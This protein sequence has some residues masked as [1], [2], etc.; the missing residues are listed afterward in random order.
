M[1]DPNRPETYPRRVL[2]AVTGLSP[3]V[4]TETLYALAVQRRPPFIPTEVV[5]VTTRTGAEH[6]WLMLLSE[7]Q[8]WFH[9]FCQDYG[10]TGIAFAENSIR[11]L[12]D[13]QGN[14][15]DD[16][17]T[18]EDNECAADYLAD[19]VRELTQDPS[20]A[21]HVSIAGGRKTMGYYLGYALSLYGRLQDRL[22]HVLIS[23]PFES[24]PQFFYPTCA[25]RIIYALD[26]QQTPLDSSQAKVMLAEIPFVS[27][28]H[29][30]PEALL[31]GKARFSEAGGCGCQKALGTSESGSRSQ[32]LQ[33][34]RCRPDHSFVPG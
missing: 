22:S 8:G 26:K 4:V 13:S 20:C 33:D 15:A 1:Y 23:P 16:I 10:L 12:P 30:L 6:A 29:G 7:D 24:H 5:L 25:Q 17:R 27:L 3:Q 11:I 21:L 14:L 9:R 34:L 2:V 31:H 28:R 18:P 32:G 19:L